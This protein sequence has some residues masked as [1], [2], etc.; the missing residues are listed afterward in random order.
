MRDVE[1]CRSKVRLKRLQFDFHLL[2]QLQIKRTQRLVEQQDVGLQHHAAGDGHALLLAARKLVHPALLHTGEADAFEHFADL[3]GNDVLRLAPAPQAIADVL[4]DAHHR[5]QCEMLEHHVHGALVGRGVEDRAVLDQNVTRR[6][7]KKPGDHPHD[8]GLAA[9]GGTEDREERAL[10]H[11]EADVVD[12]RHVAEHLH[13]VD[14]LQIRQ[15]HALSLSR[16][17]P[18]QRRKLGRPNIFACVTEPR[19]RGREQRL[20]WLQDLRAPAGTT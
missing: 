19:S 20:R 13:Q 11:F 15:R 9:A 4:L 1:K 16:V 17:G 18:A 3:A 10:R 5:E 6:W 12:R 2:A 8:R 7:L 14:A